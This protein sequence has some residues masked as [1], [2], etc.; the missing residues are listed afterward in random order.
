MKKYRNKTGLNL[1]SIS[2]SNH[3]NKHGL[4]NFKDF[5][6]DGRINILDCRPHNPHLQHAKPNFMTR[7]RLKK[8]PIYVVLED[9][10]KVHVMSKK[11]RKEEPETVKQ[12]LQAVKKHPESLGEMERQQPTVINLDVEPGASLGEIYKEDVTKEGNKRTAFI[13]GQKKPAEGEEL[14]EHIVNR[15]KKKGFSEKEAEAYYKKNKTVFNLPED[16]LMASTIRHEMEHAKQF[17]KEKELK[18]KAHLPG[19]LTR[20]HKYMEGWQ[21]DYYKQKRE[22]EA[23]EASKKMI[24][25]RRRK[26]YGAR[27]YATRNFVR[28]VDQKEPKHVRDR[29]MGLI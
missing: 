12:F 10:S 2:L 27:K 21:G 11:A 24:D 4:G 3:I 7:Q 29:D 18:E 8:L 20:L 13:H 5:D 26:T 15:L 16:E 9:G 19:G 28:T 6:K 1:K 14:K 22:K 17:E 25:K 23:R